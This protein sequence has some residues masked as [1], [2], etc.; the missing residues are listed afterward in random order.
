[1]FCAG[2]LL[3]EVLDCDTVVEELAAADLL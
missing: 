1:V 2:L 3:C